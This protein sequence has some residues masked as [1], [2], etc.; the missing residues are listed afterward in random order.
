MNKIFAITAAACVALAGPAG[1]FVAKNSLQVDERDDGSF[2][3]PGVTANAETDYWCAAGDYVKSQS[4]VLPSQII[5]RLTPVPRPGDEG[6]AFSLTEP[7]NPIPEAVGAADTGQM[8][9]GLARSFCDETD[10]N[11]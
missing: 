6:M 4:E 5:Y 9:V 3:V 11:G 8:T 1:A 7:A 10:S 2:Y